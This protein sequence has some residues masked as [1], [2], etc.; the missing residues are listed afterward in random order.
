MSN[1]NPEDLWVSHDAGGTF[2]K[3]NH[4]G[5]TV[6][7]VAHSSAANTFILEDGGGVDHLNTVVT[8]V[9]GTI[10]GSCGSACG[11]GNPAV[12]LAWSVGDKANCTGTT[13][14]WGNGECFLN[15]NADTVQ[16]GTPISGFLT[17]CDT[18]T[19][20]NNSSCQT[21]NVLVYAAVASVIKWS[22]DSNCDCLLMLV[23][24]NQK[25][26]ID[27]SLSGLS[28]WLNASEGEVDWEGVSMTQW[29]TEYYSPNL[30]LYPHDVT[31]VYVPTSAGRAMPGKYVNG[32]VFS[33][34]LADGT[35]EPFGAPLLKVYT[36]AGEPGSIYTW[37]DTVTQRGPGG[38]PTQPCNTQSIWWH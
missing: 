14:L 37:D 12:T 17:S 35:I 30:G 26:R 3:V 6:Q 32:D 25:Y 7:A 33:I 9:T 11:G 34:A 22:E 10:S 21:Y 19:K 5:L 15:T 31:I 36:V 18:F 4:S 38:D 23:S 24:L 20:A 29:C 28:H 16:P 8:Q 13:G 2:N 1:A 27:S